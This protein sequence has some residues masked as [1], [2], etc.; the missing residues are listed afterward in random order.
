MP[1]QSLVLPSNLILLAELLSFSTTHTLL[2]RL[3]GHYS[4]P[5]GHRYGICH[6]HGLM[7]GKAWEH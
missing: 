6:G 4:A 5:E 3:P 1:K 7:V 2:V